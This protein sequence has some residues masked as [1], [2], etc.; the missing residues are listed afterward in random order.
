MLVVIAVVTV[1][2][3]L[4]LMARLIMI[5][6]PVSPASRFG[7]DASGG[8]PFLGS[9]SPVLLNRQLPVRIGKAVHFALSVAG[10]FT[11]TALEVV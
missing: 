1:V 4:L 8:L 5:V 6:R 11:V 9:P 10:P 3:P 2:V 7:L